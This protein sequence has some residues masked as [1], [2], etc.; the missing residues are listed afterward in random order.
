MSSCFWP[1]NEG[2]VCVKLELSKFIDRT[3]LLWVFKA[4]S[5]DEKQVVK[6]WQRKFTQ[7]TELGKRWLEDVSWPPN[8][9]DGFCLCLILWFHFHFILLKIIW[10]NCLTALTSTSASQLANLWTVMAVCRQA[11]KKDPKYWTQG[12]KGE[13]KIQSFL[14]VLLSCKEHI[15]KY[16]TITTYFHMSV[17]NNFTVNSISSIMQ[18]FISC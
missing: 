5:Q 14:W 17:W 3:D 15:L 13:L 4:G 8:W 6:S 9:I 16:L 18:S 12:G 1:D 11:G 10:R 2:C 7:W